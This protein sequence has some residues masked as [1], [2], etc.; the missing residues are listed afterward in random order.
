MSLGPTE[1]ILIVLVLFVGLPLYFLPTLIG[2]KKK[3]NVAI[4][5]INVFLGVTF[6][7]WVGSLIWA[8]ASPRKLNFEYVCSK[9]GYKSAL[10]QPVTIFVCPQCKHENQ[11]M[12][13]QHS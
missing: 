8:I 2:Y 13:Y 11:A 10:D 3:N 7:G 12:S 1:L 5:L 4:I 9:C 6:I